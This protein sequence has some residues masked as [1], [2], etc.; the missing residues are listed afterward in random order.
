M[1]T[2]VADDRYLVKGEEIIELLGRVLNV[3]PNVRGMHLTVK[4]GE[5]PVVTWEQLPTRKAD[6]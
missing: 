1:N 6:A 2:G 5:S 3:P 4:I